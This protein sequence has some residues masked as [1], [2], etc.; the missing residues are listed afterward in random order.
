MTDVRESRPHFAF[1]AGIV[2]FIII[3]IIFIIIIFII[4]YLFIYILASKS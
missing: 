3:F 2:F 1:R 4:F